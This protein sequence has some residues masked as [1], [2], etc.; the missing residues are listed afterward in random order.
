MLERK[1]QKIVTRLARTLG[2]LV[3]HTYDSRRSAKGFPDLVLVRDRVVW[4]ELKSLRGRLRAMQ[5][6]WLDA[7]RAAGQEVYLWRPC[8]LD[9]VKEVLR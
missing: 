3:Y 7:L 6:V 5:G 8:D 4:A 1:W 9:R 2:W